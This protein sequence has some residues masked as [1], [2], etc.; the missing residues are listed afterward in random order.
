[1]GP[2]DCYQYYGYYDFEINPGIN[3]ITLTNSGRRTV[4]FKD[5]GKI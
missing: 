2:N 5:G 4:V 1:M 3:S